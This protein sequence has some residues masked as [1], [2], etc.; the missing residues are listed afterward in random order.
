[1]RKY[2]TVICSSCNKEILES[3][4]KQCIVC[5]QILCSC[6]R[7]IISLKPYCLKHSIE[8]LKNGG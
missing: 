2:K 1:M 5:N 3:S 4:S 6:C 8:I 7:Y